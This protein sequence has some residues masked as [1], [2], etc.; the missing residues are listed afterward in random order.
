MEIA[1][2]NSLELARSLASDGER[3][4]P[5]RT[6]SE[7][8]TFDFHLQFEPSGLPA[9]CSGGR[10][11]GRGAAPSPPARSVAAK[12]AAAMETWVESCWWSRISS[13]VAGR[14]L[15]R[16]FRRSE[17]ARRSYHHPF[18]HQPFTSRSLTAGEDAVGT[19]SD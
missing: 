9:L 15:S 3:Q 17:G 12:R 16:R 18:I 11:A 19:G 2:S 14:M 13:P 5:Q 10:A 8:S 7:T 6:G 4:L 1:G